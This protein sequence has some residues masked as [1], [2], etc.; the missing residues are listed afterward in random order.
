MARPMLPSSIPDAPA[1]KS[2]VPAGLKDSERKKMLPIR[3]AVLP[4]SPMPV[5]IHS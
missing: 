4:I 2:Q 5:W 3:K 1:M